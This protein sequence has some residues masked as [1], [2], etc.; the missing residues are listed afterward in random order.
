M[1]RI[2]FFH[3]VFPCGGAERVTIDIANYLSGY[4]YE[5]FVALCH[6][7]Y[8]VAGIEIIEL[9]NQDINSLENANAFIEIINSLFI[10]VFVLPI[11][12]LK[13]LDYI[14]D[15]VHCKLVF[16]PHSIPLWE[17]VAKVAD[18]GKR[19]EGSWLKMLKWRLVTCPREKW[20]P[21]YDKPFIEQHKNLYGRA[22]AY[23]VLC[24]DYKY[25]LIKKL[26]VPFE[27]NK[28]HVIPNSE[29]QI[30]SVNHHKKKQIL[31]V[32][33]FTYV[34]KRVDRLIDVWKRIYKQVPDWEL[35]L[36]G[37][38]VERQN[39]QQKATACNLQ[40]IRFLGY[41][42]DVSGFYRD[43]S[44]LCL[45][46]TFEGWG[47]C[48]TEAQANGVVPVA[49]DCGA[50]V[51]EIISPSG[52]NGFLVSPFNQSKY[53]RTLLKL[54]KDPDMLKQMRQNVVVKAQEYSPQIVG[55]KWK[56]LFES[57]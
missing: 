20:F 33:R 7:T 11:H 51:R 15:G 14:M 52:V 47:L 16:A 17:A 8:D 56:E 55:K 49:Y 26:G 38:G 43:A 40:R 31:F 45:T 1:K 27:N 12:L 50:G 37:D 57:L 35:L 9:P 48:L 53:A 24:E 34:D 22:D 30:L 19:A 10:D 39:L 36:I 54:L 5:S 4:G 2:L 6:K 29:R 18:K 21:K 32:G 44:V 13:H 28:F 25:K 3:E 23:V 46:S 42:E 41:Q